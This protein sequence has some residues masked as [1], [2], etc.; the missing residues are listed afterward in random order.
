MKIKPKYNKDYFKQFSPLN[1]SRL[2]YLSQLIYDELEITPDNE[3]DYYFMWLPLWLSYE[4]TKEICDK[5]LEKVNSEFG[6]AKIN[7]HE[8][9]K[10]PNI[11]IIN[12]NKFYFFYKEL[13]NFWNKYNPKSNFAEIYYQKEAGIGTINGQDFKLHTELKCR[14][15]GE[16]YDNLNKR[17]SRQKILELADFDTN[18]MEIK[19]TVLKGTQK[20]KPSIYTSE[21]YFIRDLVKELR[22]NISL[23][24]K[25]LVNNGGNLTLI[26]EKAEPK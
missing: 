14:V 2:L 20:K 6:F 9:D 23:T 17:V 10:C 15:F 3:E 12:K 19:M 1:I 16:L 7:I 5:L 13:K 18:A 8:E 24:P 21:T 11:A 4:M 22:K 25:Q 26:G